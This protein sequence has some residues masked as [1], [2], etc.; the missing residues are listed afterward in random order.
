MPATCNLTIS[1][2]TTPPAR[3]ISWTWTSLS[4]HWHPCAIPPKHVT[5]HT[6][7]TGCGTRYLPSGFEASIEWHGLARLGKL[8]EFSANSVSQPSNI[9]RVHHA[10]TTWVDGMPKTTL[11]SD[12]QS[13]DVQSYREYFFLL[14]NYQ[15]WPKNLR[16]FH[17]SLVQTRHQ[18]G[19]RPGRLQMR[20]VFTVP[21]CR[22]SPEW[23]AS[24]G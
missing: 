9:M 16:T 7:T 17:A 4:L 1:F 19:K 2:P 24:N 21:R 15:P 22:T 23:N 3:P 11:N 13:D 6:D 10:C 20:A 5:C 12:G 18:V 14:W 8:P